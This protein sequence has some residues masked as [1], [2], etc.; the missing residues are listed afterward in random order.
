MLLAQ[1][2][3]LLGA[4]IGYFLGLLQHCGNRFMLGIILI[5]QRGCHLREF[6]RSNTWRERNSEVIVPLPN[7]R[8]HRN[9]SIPQVK[10]KTIVADLVHSTFPVKS[11]DDFHQ[12]ILR[13]PFTPGIFFTSIEIP[14][15]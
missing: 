11:F 2:L 15:G 14:F 6:T 4:E 7:M 12:I 9:N 13:H 8:H 1:A 3:F 10:P 5:H